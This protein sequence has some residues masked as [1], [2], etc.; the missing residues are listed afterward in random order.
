M[1]RVISV[2]LVLVMALAL[3]AGCGGEQ[4]TTTGTTEK[5][6][7]SDSTTMIQA[8]K[9]VKSK[10]A[11]TC[12]LAVW[13]ETEPQ[14]VVLAEAIEAFADETGVEVEVNWAGGRDTRK[15][16]QPALDT[17]ETI[18]IFDEDVERVNITWGKY[19]LDLQ[20]MYDASALNGSQNATLINLAKELGDGSLKSVPYQP[21]AFL[22]M[23][24]K[25]AFDEAGIS[26]V[27]ANW[28][29]FMAACQKLVDAGYVP[30]TVDDAYMASFFGY[31]VDR[32]AGDEAAEAIAAGDF[33][34]EA[35][36]KT[37]EVLE[38]MVEKGYIDPRAAAN[39]WPAGQG[40]IADGSV[41]MYLNGTWLPNEIKNQT[42]EGF[43]WGSFALPQIAEA[44]DGAE[45]N[46]FGAQCFGINK[47]TEYPN[48]AFALIEWLT[49]GEW[50]Q[51]LADQT[52]G[53]PM[54]N[55]ATWPEALAE[56][57][58]CI[59]NTTKRLNWAVGMENEANVN[60]SIKENLSKMINGSMDAQQFADAF[61]KTQ[62]G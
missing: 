61:S 18:D 42:P 21:S 53:V 47:D 12:L 22:M 38:E 56:A 4:T 3:F 62:L 59:D 20:D 46:N 29:E 58:T 55:D 15:T 26:A 54:A 28:D 7:D 23:Y 17:G 5:S 13:A 19:L 45:A 60:A 24:N 44:G 6:G 8:P 39:V 51:K 43:R 1:K 50:D 40:N 32:V 36:L 57:Q 2:I 49:S 14:G 52:L 30:L 11:E 41:A 25:D 35:V 10:R 48:A 34:H 37:A 9:P 33:S 27:P 16:L 31:M